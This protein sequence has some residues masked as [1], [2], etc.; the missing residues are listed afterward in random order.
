MTL[1]SP[2]ST[3]ALEQRIR[4]R[5]ARANHRLVKSR[6]AQARQNLGEYYVVDDRNCVLQSQCDLETLALQLRVRV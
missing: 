2:T 3:S 1:P 4:R 5:L 6:S